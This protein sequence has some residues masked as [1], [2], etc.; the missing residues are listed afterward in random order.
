MLGDDIVIN[1]NALAA[2]Y[3]ETLDSLGVEISPS[4]THKSE[5]F[6]EFAKRVIFFDREVTPFPFNAI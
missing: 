2:K 1:N 3:K 4:K 6:Y 5:N